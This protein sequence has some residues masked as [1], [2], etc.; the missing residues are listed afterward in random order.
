MGRSSKMSASPMIP[1]YRSV[2]GGQRVSC[3]HRYQGLII[4]IMPRGEVDFKVGI[5]PTEGRLEGTVGRDERPKATNQV[6]GRKN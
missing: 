5:K 2:E 1:E 6:V 4:T 3:W